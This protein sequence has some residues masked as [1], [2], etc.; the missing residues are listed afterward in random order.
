MSVTVEYVQR[1]EAQM[2]LAQKEYDK[3]VKYRNY[4]FGFVGALVA[5]I[6]GAS[7][8]ATVA[9]ALWKTPFAITAF[10]LL[11]IACIAGFIVNINPPWKDY[12][13]VTLIRLSREKLV[14]AKEDY[15]KA[16]LDLDVK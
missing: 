10:I 11:W 7:F 16:L 8:L 13:G 9:F 14:K 15:Q 4:A 2:K 5:S 12:G 1:L 6:L 3:L